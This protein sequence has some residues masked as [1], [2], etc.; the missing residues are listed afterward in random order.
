MM[1][2]TIF[3]NVVCELGEGPTYDRR[4]DTL[5]WFDIVGKKL[6]E[7]RWPDGETIVHDLPFMASALA[8][9]DD[10]RQLVAAEDGLYI[11]DVASGTL[12]LHKPLEADMPANRSNDARVHPCGAFWIGTM[13]KD[14][15][16][17]EGSI[18]WYF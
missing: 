6:L 10:H 5:F 18:Y 9:I 7:K 15:A 14:E 16:A 3:S 8:A 17:P 1:A 2:A 13:R 12:T 4:R 11:R